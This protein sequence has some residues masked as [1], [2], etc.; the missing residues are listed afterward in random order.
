MRVWAHGAPV[1]NGGIASGSPATTP[2]PEEC[3]LS[4]VTSNHFVLNLMMPNFEKSESL[5]ESLKC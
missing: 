2:A 1:W 3:H 5:S 4:V